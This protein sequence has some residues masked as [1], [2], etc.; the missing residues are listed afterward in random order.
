[1]DEPPYDAY[2]ILG[3]PLSQRRGS[4]LNITVLCLKT[5]THLGSVSADKRFSLI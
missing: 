4:A 3:R 1:M 2:T 5:V